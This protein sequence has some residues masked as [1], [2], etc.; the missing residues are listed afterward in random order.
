MQCT[1]PPSQIVNIK[2]TS[3]SFHWKLTCSCMILL[4][5]C[6]FGIKQQSLIMFILHTSSFD[7]LRWWSCTLHSLTALSNVFCGNLR[8]FLFIFLRKSSNDDVC[9]MNMISDCCLMP[10]Q[11]LLSNILQEQ[12]NFQWND[13]EARFILDQHA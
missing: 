9:R 8:L 1:W 13:D 3:S 12:V 11:Q 2:R 6:C 10:K 4:N 5:N 7:N